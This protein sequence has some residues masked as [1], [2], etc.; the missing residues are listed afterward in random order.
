M[1]SKDKIKAQAKLL[2]SELASMSGP[3]KYQDALELM[4]KLNDFRNW[5]TMSAVVARQ[6]AAGPEKSESLSLNWVGDYGQ[7]E[8][9]GAGFLYR[10]PVSVD[11]SMTAVVLVRAESKDEAIDLAREVACNGQ[12][13]ME[14]D[15]GN[16]RGRADYY[17][18]DTSEDAVFR[19]SEPATSVESTGP[20]FV[21]IGAYRVQLSNLGD[22]DD[23]LL[24][25]DVSVYNPDTTEGDALSLQSCLAESSSP[26]EVTSFCRQVARLLHEAAPDPTKVLNEVLFRAAYRV[27]QGGLTPENEEYLKQLLKPATASPTQR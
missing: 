13:R 5:K 11:T 18:G 24:W 22:G 12:V 4:A 7:T 10:V 23:G 21:Q 17:C 14:V 3:L 25:A 26:E 27:V 8:I 15:D 20:G 19:L 9:P 6:A 2:V 1:L 16:Y